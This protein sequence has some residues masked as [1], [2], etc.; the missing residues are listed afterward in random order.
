MHFEIHEHH[1]KMDKFQFMVLG[2]F[3]LLL[4]MHSIKAHVPTNILHDITIIQNPHAH[5][6]N[7]EV[8]Y[9][10]ESVRYKLLC[11]FHGLFN[12]FGS[13]KFLTS[14]LLGMRFLFGIFHNI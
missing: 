6:V 2:Y 1:H 9:I 4:G 10:M 8:H 11:S 12:L 13:P 14:N 5:C 3:T 7:H